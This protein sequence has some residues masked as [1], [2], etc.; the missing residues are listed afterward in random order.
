ME[1]LTVSEEKRKSSLCRLAWF[2]LLNKGNK[3][4]SVSLDDIYLLMKAGAR[5]VVYG[6]IDKKWR[7][8]V[9]LYGHIF[10]Y[11]DTRY[12]FIADQRRGFLAR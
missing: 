12:F 8:E 5:R 7:V 3:T 11:E 2:E 1:R 4:A 10:V 9:D 6:L